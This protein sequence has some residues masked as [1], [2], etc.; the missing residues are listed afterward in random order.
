MASIPAREPFQFLPPTQ[1]IHSPYAYHQP[2]AAILLAPIERD[3]HS[4]EPLCTDFIKS[5]IMAVRAHAADYVPLLVGQLPPLLDPLEK[6]ALLVH[7]V[8][9]AFSVGCSF[10]ARPSRSKSMRCWDIWASAP[11]MVLHWDQFNGTCGSLLVPRAGSFAI[12]HVLHLTSHVEEVAGVLWLCQ[13]AIPALEQPSDKKRRKLT[14]EVRTN[15]QCPANPV[16]W[17]TCSCPGCVWLA[18][19]ESSSPV[20]SVPM[21]PCPC[22]QCHCGRVPCP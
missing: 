20:Q 21:E 9:R 6:L 12:Q 7:L 18:A 17:R 2:L 13:S 10:T 16:Y 22:T 8:K 1:W 5:Q 4:A 11:A 14:C 19:E 3:L 15:I